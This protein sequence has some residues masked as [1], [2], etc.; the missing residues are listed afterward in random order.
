MTSMVSVAN[1]AMARSLFLCAGQLIDHRRP[2]PRDSSGAPC[3]IVAAIEEYFSLLDAGVAAMRRARLR[4]K[5]YRK[6]AVEHALSMV[7]EAKEA[8]GHELFTYV[9]SGSRGW[10]KYYSSVGAVF[11]R[12]GNVPR[13]VIQLDLSQVQMVDPPQGA[14]GRRTKVE[15][16]DLLITITADIGRVAVAPANLGEAYINQHVAIARPRVGVN[17]AYLAWFVASTRGQ[18]Q[19]TGLQRGMTK[20]GLGLDDIRAL[21]VPVPPLDVQ[22]RVAVSLHELTELVE[23]TDRQLA[24]RINWA[25]ALRRSIL[26]AA[27]SGELVPQ[28]PDDEPASAVLKRVLGQQPAA[29]SV[30]ARK[31][32]ITA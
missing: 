13:D 8:A 20:A 23:R 15:V 5:A 24:R 6:A 10:A 28:N 26:S 9:T 32:A 25:H 1:P 29:P 4:M 16:G 31:R 30:R 14:E 17:S 12:V 21:R 22:D 3:R 27:I 11:V 18:A 7:S 2:R 19:L